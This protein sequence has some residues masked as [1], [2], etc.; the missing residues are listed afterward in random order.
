MSAGAHFRAAL[1][2]E[3]PLQIVGTINAYTALL[4][5]RAGH[6]A[7]SAV[8]SRIA[9][10]LRPQHLDRIGSQTIEFKQLPDYFQRYL[11]G[12]VTGRTVVQIGD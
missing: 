5:E 9:N 7:N 8:W 4:A 2:T 6:K 1:E 11:D 3:R 10:D 12:K